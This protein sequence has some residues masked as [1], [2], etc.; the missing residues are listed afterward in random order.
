M[1]SSLTAA[2]QDKCNMVNLP[3]LMGMDD[4][5]G[6]DAQGGWG[7]RG[8]DRDGFGLGEELV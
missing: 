2:L 1:G 3:S 4:S 5:E 6:A 8:K 7:V